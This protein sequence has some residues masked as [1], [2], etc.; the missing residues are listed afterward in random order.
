M[1]GERV[2]VALRSIALDEFVRVRSAKRVGLVIDHEWLTSR[3]GEQVDLPPHDRSGEAE[4]ER[5]LR[6]Q[7]STARLELGP[8]PGFQPALD[9]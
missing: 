6:S 9:K 2:E 1:S 7:P 8:K 5:N 3:L 4:D